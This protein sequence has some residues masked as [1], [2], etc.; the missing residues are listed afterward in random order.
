[1]L[2][3][4]RVRRFG[5]I[6]QPETWPRYKP[7]WPRYPLCKIELST[8]DKTNRWVKLK[9]YTIIFLQTCLYLQDFLF[10]EG[11]YKIFLRYN[12]IYGLVLE[13][14]EAEPENWIDK[15]CPFP[16]RRKSSSPWVGT[17]STRLVASVV[18]WCEAPESMKHIV[19]HYICLWW[20]IS[21]CFCIKLKRRLWLR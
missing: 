8:W 13:G 10:M 20:R 5:L 1:M 16:R 21:H 6:D 9:I 11:T 14:K 12:V 19:L 3:Q 15:P 7:S 17:T 18:I 2:R 4:R